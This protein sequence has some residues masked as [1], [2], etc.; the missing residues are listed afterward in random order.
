MFP[1]PKVPRWAPTGLRVKW[2]LDEWV[3]ESQRK[4]RHP[5]KAEFTKRD[6]D[7]VERYTQQ[8]DEMVGRRIRYMR[9]R[10]GLRVVDLAKAIGISTATLSRIERGVRPAKA[11]EL[12]R[13]CIQFGRRMDDMVA[14]P[15]SEDVERLTCWHKAKRPLLIPRSLEEAVRIGLL[16]SEHP[17]FD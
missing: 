10:A 15:R 9:A 6:A 13:V 8:L 3:T 5:R 11:S 14:F 2:W 7:E 1:D 12:M 17:I 16:P 4:E